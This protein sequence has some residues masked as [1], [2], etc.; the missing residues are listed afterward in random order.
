MPAT[1]LAM[2]KVLA[3]VLFLFV[4]AVVAVLEYVDL[5]T[6]Y[7]PGSSPIN[8]GQFGTSMLVKMLKDYGL[9]VTYVSNWS[10]VRTSKAE[11]KVCILIVSPEYGYTYNEVENIVK[12]LTTSGGVLVVADETTTSNSLLELLGVQVRIYGNRLLD[13]H[14]DFYPK[15]I[16]YVENRE[17]ALRLDKASEVHNCD[18]VIGIAESYEYLSETAK[19]KPAGCI[20]HL[21]DLV[22]LVLGDGSPLTNQAQQLGGTYKELAKFIALTIRRYCGAGCRVFVEAGKY[23]SDK[24]LFLRLYDQRDE[25]SLLVFLNEVL[26]YLRA[27]RSFLVRDPLEGLGEEVVAV[28]AILAVVAVSAKLGK[29]NT[30]LAKTIESFTWRG[31]DDFSKIYSAICEVLT[32]LGCEPRPSEE[33]VKCLERAGYKSKHS[34]ELARFMRFSELV[35]DRRIFSYFPIWQAMI[36]KALKHSEE[37]LE[38]LEK[39]LLSGRY[40]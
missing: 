35:L 31:R 3:L 7:P 16:F 37:L 20:E 2:L 32:L 19:L 14:Y 39:N 40:A 34:V 15:A 13:E 11:G 12:I 18:T 10:Y 9:R 4:V 25:A 33:L 26:Y 1:F 27:V 8:P 23:V 29:R 30:E 22:A 6:P 36:N 21:D 38:V 5:P 28:F 17:I 24:N